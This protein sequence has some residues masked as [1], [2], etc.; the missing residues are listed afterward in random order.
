MIGHA[1]TV[2]YNGQSRKLISEAHISY[3]NEDMYT[4]N[5]LWDTGATI[6][7]ISKAVVDRL[8]LVP[9]SKTMMRGASGDKIANVYLVDILLRNNVVVKDIQVM[10]AEIGGQGID[11]LIG[12]DIIL[13]G[14]FAVTNKDGNTKFTFQIPT[15]YDIDFVKQIKKLDE[16]ET[17]D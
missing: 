13:L 16:E 1:F 10:E 4:P 9:I 12:M 3:N 11:L 15:A 2:K 5:A 6:S 7:C 14:D 8:G 17:N